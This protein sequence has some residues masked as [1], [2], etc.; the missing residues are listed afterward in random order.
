MMKDYLWLGGGRYFLR[1]LKYFLVT[2]T[3]S[4]MH[5]LITSETMGMFNPAK[6]YLNTR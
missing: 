4:R 3:Y 5:A 2:D 6:T 1:A